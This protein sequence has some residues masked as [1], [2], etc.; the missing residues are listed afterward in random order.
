MPRKKKPGGPRRRETFHLPVSLLDAVTA[1]AARQGMPKLD[2]VG[3]VLA[4]R[5]NMPYERTSPPF[6]GQEELEL[7]LK[8]S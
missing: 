4:E 8:A 5:L 7:P 2:Y 3:L 6:E 1:E